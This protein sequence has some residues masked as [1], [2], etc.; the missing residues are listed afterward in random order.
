MESIRK[1]VLDACRGLAAYGLGTGIGGQVS[2]RV[3]GEDLMVSHAFDKTFEE[4]HAD[5]I[6]VVDFEGRPV[7][8]DRPVSIGIEFHHGIYRQRS[9]VH[10][11]VHSHGFLG[12]NPGGLSAA[13]ADFRECDHALSWQDLHKSERRFRLD[14]RG[15]WQR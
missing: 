2:I 8:T 3:P 1:D 15:A 7:G 14:R 11:I 6:F 12:Y 10:A 13:F 5:D 9:N 4:M